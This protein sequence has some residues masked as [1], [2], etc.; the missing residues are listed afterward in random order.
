M[1]RGFLG[2]LHPVGYYFCGRSRAMA[3]LVGTINCC[4]R[5]I[6]PGKTLPQHLLHDNEKAL[7][8]AFGTVVRQKKKA[9][10]E[11]Y[12]KETERC[13]LYLD[14]HDLPGVDAKAVAGAHARDL[15]VQGEYG[16]NYRS[17]W[18]DEKEARCFCLVE[19]PDE[20]TATRVHREAHGLVAD[21]IRE[22]VEGS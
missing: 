19:A 17:Y 21:E 5:T 10:N 2:A 18:V 1:Q 12:R 6:E 16:V 14:M 15:E 4:L 7:R 11:K 8:A 22:V 9:L 3:P 20:E 13:K